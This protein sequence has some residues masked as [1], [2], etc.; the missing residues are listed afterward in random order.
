MSMESRENPMKRILLASVL[1]G[2][3]LTTLGCRTTV[4]V[5]NDARVGDLGED[6]KAVMDHAVAQVKPSLVRIQVVEPDYREGRENKWISFGSGT[7]ITE[8]GF[9]MTNHHVAGKAVQIICTM[10][11]REE[12]PAKLIGTDAATDIAVIKLT[13]EKETKFPVARFGDSEAVRVGDSVLAMG[14]PAALSQSV[15]LGIVAN[16][17]MI[18][19][20]SWGDYK[21][22]IDGENVGELVRWI[23]HDAAIFPGNSG[24]PLVNLNGEIVGVNEIGLGLGG[25][26]PGNLAKKVAFEI[27]EKQMV[28]RAYIGIGLQRL[29]KKSANREG[30]LVGSVL[31][32]SPAEKSG[33]KPGDLL[34]EINGQKLEGRFDE[35]LPGINNVIADLPIGKEATFVVRRG[36]ANQ[37]LKVTAEQREPALIPTEEL[38]EWG[39]TAHNL[40]LWAKIGMARDTKEGVLVTSTRSGGPVA[41][42]KPEIKEGDVIVKVD[43]VAVHNVKEL[44]EITKR[45]TEGKSDFVPALV[46]FE[47][48]AEQFLTVVQVGIDKLQDPGKEVQ[49]AWLPIETQ[50]LT[51]DISKQLGIAEQKGVR[52]TRLYSDAPKDYPLKVGDV[53]TKLDGEI[54]DASK[55]VDAEVFKTAIRQYRVGKEVTLDI[56]REGKSEQVTVKLLPS[57][58]ASREL[59]RYRDLDFDFIAREASFNDRQKP[60]MQGQDFSVVADSV[61]SGGWADLGGLRVGDAIL[62]IGGQP[63]KGVA[64]VEQ[65]MKS[66]REAKRAAVVFFVRR[67]TRNLFLEMEPNW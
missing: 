6:R 60:T 2:A 66:A 36:E 54:V 24:G 8:D 37:T 30:V 61:T 55:P 10:S 32:D 18:T 1:C 28:E 40:T 63:I 50:V 3:A 43:G 20:L 16:A 51:T 14:S 34:L 47:R 35:D 26:I 44:E 13:P 62:E 7:I 49:K 58:Q 19:P 56:L 9:V 59:K 23:G 21:F 12:I 53:V 33:F 11:N 42:A 4:A 65:A 5:H 46:T 17:E 15:T 22:E 64:D 57:P 31:K 25:A 41:Q 29:M 48:E 27:I 67:G 38:R 52:V 45:I 39:M